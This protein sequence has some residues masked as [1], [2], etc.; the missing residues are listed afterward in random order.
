MALNMT[1]IPKAVLINSSI[2]STIYEL[3]FSNF[4]VIDYF[5]AIKPLIFFIIGITAYSIFVFKFYKFLARRDILE[6]GLHKHSDTFSG[7]IKNIVHVLLY[8][9]ENLLLIPII[10]FFWF[11]VIT[12][13][14]LL[15][16]KG[17]STN[18]ILLISVSVVGAIRVSSYYNEM[19]AQE[20]AKMIPFALLGVVIVDISFF[21]LETI[22]NIIKDIPSMWV[23]LFYY[24]MFV[25][26]I[27]AVMRIVHSM[28]RLFM[29]DKDSG[30]GIG[31]KK[32]E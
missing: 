15:I 26:L 27:E 16:S 6:W 22:I 8:T 24:L 31:K 10:V 13:L 2:G 20:L 9:L 5:I 14:L 11:S 23:P 1:S 4:S 25:V 32:E 12:L 28:T 30:K 7:F 17:H 18:T 29:S 19:L 21:S 3:N